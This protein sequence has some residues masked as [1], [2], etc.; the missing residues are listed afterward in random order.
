MN[1]KLLVAAVAV[2]A[3]ATPSL[4]AEFYIVQ[5][6][7]TKR[8]TIVEQRPTTRTSVVVGPGTVYT[9]RTEAESAM[10]TVK[11]CES[12]GTVGGPAVVP[13]PAPR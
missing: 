4:A 9:T 1:T 11:V 5:D 7:G 12:G 2:A 8:C 3:Y 10:G 6:T 13:G